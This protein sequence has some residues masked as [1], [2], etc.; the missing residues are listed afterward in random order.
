MN[1][2]SNVKKGPD[3][4]N[5]LPVRNPWTV[6]A[7]GVP[8]SVMATYTADTTG[9]HGPR[10]NYVTKNNGVVVDRGFVSRAKGDFLN[11]L[12]WQST[13]KKLTGTL[14]LGTLSKRWTWTVDNSKSTGTM[15]P[16]P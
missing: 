16:R 8:G 3:A 10:M 5:I 6:E 1:I 7:D 15:T 2:Q 14:V 9:D 11:H 12:V 4:L 13:T